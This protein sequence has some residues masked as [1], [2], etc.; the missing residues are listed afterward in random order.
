M[1]RSI[2]KD[3]QS[4]VIGVVALS[5]DLKT[6]FNPGRNTS[7]HNALV[8]QGIVNDGQRTFPFF[9]DGMEKCSRLQICRSYDELDDMFAGMV[10]A[11][12]SI[13]VILTLLFF[14]V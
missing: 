4:N 6:D 1:S 2:I 11:F 10:S 9:R 13:S 14:R 7:D 12:L 5:L 3:G 8:V